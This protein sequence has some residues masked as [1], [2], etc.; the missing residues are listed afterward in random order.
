MQRFNYPLP[1]V[2]PYVMPGP[3][4]YTLPES[5]P[6]DMT[7]PE[8][9]SQDL[10]EDGAEDGWIASHYEFYPVDVISRGMDQRQSQLHQS[11]ENSNNA[12]TNGNNSDCDNSLV[13]LNSQLLCI[14]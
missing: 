9:Q 3:G 13:S 8:D 7:R 2:D 6:H 11:R 1:G 10:E 5:E 4:P 14:I 12:E